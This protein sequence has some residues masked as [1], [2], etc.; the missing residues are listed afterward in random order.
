MRTFVQ[1]GLKDYWPTFEEI[2]HRLHQEGL[3]IHPHQL[4]EFFLAHG[5][6]VDLRYVPTHLRQKA[7]FINDHYRGDM[8]CLAEESDEPSFDCQT[9]E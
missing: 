2:L 3:Y 6:P 1:Q 4:A 5:L 9:W 8:A 7:T